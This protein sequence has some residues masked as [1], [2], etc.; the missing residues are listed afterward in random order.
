[1][2]AESTPYMTR[3]ASCPSCK[4]SANPAAGSDDK[5]PI[6]SLDAASPVQYLVRHQVVQDERHGG[7][8]VE[9]VRYPEVGFRRT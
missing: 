3:P 6:A 9:G 5:N 8:S 7:C 4:G 1:M 2:A